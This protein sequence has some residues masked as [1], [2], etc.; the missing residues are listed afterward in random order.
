MTEV[1]VTLFEAE[2][3]G[4]SSCV[5]R[6]PGLDRCLNDSGFKNSMVQSDWNDRLDIVKPNVGT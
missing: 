6:T 3:C 4:E 5:D 2:L 1:M